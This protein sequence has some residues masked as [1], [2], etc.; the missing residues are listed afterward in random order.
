V[1]SSQPEHLGET[2]VAQRA[3]RLPPPVI[4]APVFFLFGDTRGG[5]TAAALLLPRWRRRRARRRR[6][7]QPLVCWP[8][9]LGRRC[10]VYSCRIAILTA[11]SNPETTFLAFHSS[12]NNARLCSTTRTP[13][14]SSLDAGHR[15][16]D[17]QQGRRQQHEAPG[18]Q[19]S[20]GRRRARN[21]AHARA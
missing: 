10:L 18:R 13:G 19:A 9:P 17:V 3:R 15:A 14:E 12:S 5:I 8:N 11:A 20:V 21:R 6:P 7:Q 4:A 1:D 2:G 16:E